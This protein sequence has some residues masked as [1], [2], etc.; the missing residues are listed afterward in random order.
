MC[1]QIDS[2]K[3]RLERVCEV[4]LRD[5]PEHV[6]DCPSPDS[7]DNSKADKV[8]LTR[9]NC[10][11]ARKVKRLSNKRLGNE[12]FEVDCHNHLRNSYLCNYVKKAL[13]KFLT[14]ELK[15][16]LDNINSRLHVIILRLA[17]TGA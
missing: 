16:N 17:F 15:E 1:F 5:N 2:L 14:V 3:H 7:I 11:T 10:S 9:D 13:S 6:N 8:D 12:Y 4:S